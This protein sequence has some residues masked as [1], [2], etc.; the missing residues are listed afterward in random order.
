MGLVAIVLGLG[1][2]SVVVLGLGWFDGG[3]DWVWWWVVVLGL[4]WW[5]VG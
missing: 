4:G 2:W 3:A 1:W 5:W